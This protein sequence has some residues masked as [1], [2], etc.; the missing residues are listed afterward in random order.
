MKRD[1][2]GMNSLLQ[3]GQCEDLKWAFTTRY[4]WRCVFCMHVS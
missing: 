3:S 2:P 4:P 1:A